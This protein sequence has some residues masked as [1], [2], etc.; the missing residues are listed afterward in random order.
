MEELSALF[1]RRRGQRSRRCG[2]LRGPIQHG[3][4]QDDQS[5]NDTFHE[6]PSFSRTTAKLQIS[7]SMRI[8]GEGISSR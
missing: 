4:E 7:I 1:S 3:K 6:I 5:G 2:L 8:S